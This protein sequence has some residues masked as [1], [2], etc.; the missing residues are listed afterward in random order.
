MFIQTWI[1]PY[2]LLW[3]RGPSVL[4]AGSM[5]ITLDKRINLVNGFDLEIKNARLEDEGEY[6]CQLSTYTPQEQTHTLEILGMKTKSSW[7]VLMMTVYNIKFF[8]WQMRAISLHFLYIIWYHI[9]VPPTVNAEPSHITISKGESVS[10]QCQGYGNPMPTITWARYNNVLLPNG[11]K[12]VANN[13]YKIQRADRHHAGI[14]VCSAFNGVGPPVSA[15]VD[16][17][18]QCKFMAY[19]I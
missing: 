18:V 12:S 17:K 15:Q 2:V 14:Y 8:M 11:E 6:V 4:S 7:L 10:L 1:G 16:V 13:T 19:I 5:K 3:K 9:A